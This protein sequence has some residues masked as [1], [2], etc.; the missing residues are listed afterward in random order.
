[1]FMTFLCIV[2]SHHNQR[3][4]RTNFHL[5]YGVTGD[6]V[7]SPP[8]PH[9]VFTVLCILCFELF[10]EPESA[11]LAS[12]KG[13]KWRYIFNSIRLSS[14]TDSQ[15]QRISAHSH[16]RMHTQTNAYTRIH[17]CTDTNKYTHTCTHTNTTL[18]H[19][20]HTHTYTTLIHTYTRT[21]IRHTHT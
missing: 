7:T 15:L 19:T 18:I 2:H 21:H 12:V 20:P 11:C 3:A 13:C 6:S 10:R 9:P 5:N 4:P 8:P 14:Q 16:A 1:M 17:K